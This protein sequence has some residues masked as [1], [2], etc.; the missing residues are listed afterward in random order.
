MPGARGAVF[1]SK[2]TRCVRALSGSGFEVQAAFLATSIAIG[3]RKV[4]HG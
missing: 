4:K 3:A 2:K 1:E